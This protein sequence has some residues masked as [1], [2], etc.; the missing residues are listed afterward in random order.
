MLYEVCEALPD[1]NP[2]EVE[3]A[4][5]H[6]HSVL[7]DMLTTDAIESTREVTA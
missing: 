3:K 5:D 1:V 4:L 7:H 2:A 6:A